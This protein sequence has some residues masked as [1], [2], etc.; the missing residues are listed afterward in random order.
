MQDELKLLARARAL[1]QEA[2]AQIHDDYYGPIF[3]YIAMRVGDHQ[4]AED[5]TSEVFLRLL[6]ALRDHTAP[7]RTLRGWLYAVAFRVV[8]DHYRRQYRRQD[9]QLHEGIPSEK[10]TPAD[11]V[12]EKINWERLQEK[13]LMLTDEQQNVIALRFGASFSIRQTAEAMNKSEGAVKQLQLRAVATLARLME[14][15]HE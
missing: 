13:L 7:D 15:G 4:T 8:K 11:M 6:S 5:L 3:R 2:L 1:E 10:P 12:A 9:Q 14:S